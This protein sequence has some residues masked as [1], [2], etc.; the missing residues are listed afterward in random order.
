MAA[1]GPAGSP[2]RGHTANEQPT[3]AHGGVASHPRRAQ[4]KPWSPQW[5]L[6]SQSVHKLFVERCFR[7]S[8]LYPRCLDHGAVS[9]TWARAWLG[10]PPGA[11]SRQSD[12]WHE[13][14]CI[15][16]AMSGHGAGQGGGSLGRIAYAYACHQRADLSVSDKD[17]GQMVRAP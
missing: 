3:V 2:I 11:R 4:L 9:N 5:R 12:G 14:I 13:A 6:A 8:M 1:S 15:A 10:L 7:R 17:E 16:R